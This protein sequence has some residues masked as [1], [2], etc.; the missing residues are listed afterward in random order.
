MSSY[1]SMHLFHT[2]HRFNVQPRSL[3]CL[4]VCSCHGMHIMLLV[5]HSRM[6]VPHGILVSVS[7][8]LI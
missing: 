6:L 4:R 8:P 1:I 7:R 3:N 5:V 2:Y